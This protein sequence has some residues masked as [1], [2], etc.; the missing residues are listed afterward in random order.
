MKKKPYAVEGK[1][2]VASPSSMRLALE[3]RLLF[4]GAVVATAAQ[5][6]DDK[7]AQDQPQ[8]QDQDTSSDPNVDSAPDF[9]THA[10]NHS[11]LGGLSNDMVNRDLQHL[12]TTLPASAGDRDATT[13]L[14]IDS[15]ANG[16]Q[17]ILKNPPLHTDVRVIDASRDGYE[18]IKEILHDRGDTSQLHIQSA[19]LD[20]KQCLGSSR[21]LGN[22]NTSDTE[23]L[24]DWGD[25]IS[26]NTSINFHGGQAF[27]GKSWL[28]QVQTLTG[29][30]VRWSDKDVVDSKQA[31]STGGSQ[32]SKTT[33]DAEKE[34][35]ALGASTAEIKEVKSLVFIDTSVKDYHALLKDIDPN[36]TVILLD[37]TK[38]GVQ[39]MVNVV[40]KYDSIDAI[41][42]ISHGGT[43]QLKLG[44][45]VLNQASIQDMYADELTSMSGHLSANADILIYGCNFGQGDIGIQVSNQLAALT[46]ADIADSTNDTGAAVLG[47]DWILENQIGMIEAL[48]INAPEWDGLLTT[49]T[50]LDWQL[51]GNHTLGATGTTYTFGG[52]TNAVTIKTTGTGSIVNDYT[53]N[54]TGGTNDPTLAFSASTTSTTSG[55]T[56]EINF[57]SSA[58]P[59]GVL[60]TQFDLRNIDAK[61]GSGAWDDRVILQAF[62]INGVQL[63]GTNI[64][65]TPRQTTGQTYSISTLTN[66]VQLDGNTSSSTNFNLPSDSVNISITSTSGTAI[67][68]V[69]ILYVSGTSGTS[70]G[71]VGLSD[72]G[73]TYDKAPLANADTG[74][75]AEDATLPK[76]AANGVIQGTTGGSVADSDPDDAT[77]TLVVSGVKAGT[78]TVTQGVGVGSS[79][80][81]TYG[82]LTLTSDGSYSYIADNANSLAA[83]ATATDTFTYT[84]K[85]PTGVVSN[86]TTLTITLTGTNDPPTLTG[87]LS[88][89]VLEGGTYVLTAADLGFTDPDNVAAAETFTVSALA[90]GTVLVNGVA[91]TS[92]T[93]TQLAAGQVSFQHNGSETTS[94]SFLV[95]VEDGNQ[96]GSVPA[97]STFNF[98]V[99]PVNDPPALTGD[100]SATVLEGGT[101]VL[102]AADLGFTDP[103]NVAAAETFTVSALAN[104][105]VLVNG[106]A[107]TS[108]TGT[109]LAAGQVSF[110]HN[111]S[112]TT[113]ASFLVNVEDGNQDGSVPANS[114]FNFSVTPVNDPPALTGDLSATVL[115]GGTYVLTAAD[116]GFTDPDNVAAAETFTVSALAN[117]TVLVNGVAATSFTGTQ[118]A[119]GQVSFQHNGSETTSASFLV[120]VEDGNQDG[121]VPVNSTFNFS[122][123]PVN[124]PP[125]LTGDLSA[126]VL[127]GGTYVLTAADL[128]F[129]DPDNVAAA[130]TFTVS[131]LANGT[132]LVNGV[133]A[134][135]FTGTQL[136]AGQ[137][138][139]QHNGSETTSAS[140]LVNVEDG[141]QDGSVPANSTFNFSVTPVNDPPALTGDL[142]ATVLE[143]GT[144]VLT[145]ADLGFTDPD[146]VA[147]AETFTVS[148][149]ANGT[150]L[151]NGVAATSFTGTQLAAGQVSFQHNGSETTS[152]SFLV[153]VEDGNQDG[154][155][156]ANST[157]NFSVTPVNDPPALTGDLS[158]TVLEGG[159]YVLTAADLG[160]TDPDNV[161]AAE[162]FTVSALANGTVLVNG[163]AATSFT[164]TQLAAGQVSFQH[165]GSETTSASF[166]VNVEDG[167]QDG[168]VPAN[169]TF[170]FSVTP[171]NDP[172]ALTGDLSATVLEGGTYVLTAADLGFTDPDNVAAAETFTVSALANGTVLV[173]G[174]AATSFTGTQ[175]AAGQVSFQHNGSETTSASFLVNVE[176]GN[177]D[178]SVPANS[179]FNFSVTPVNDPPALTGDLSATV[180]EG[181]TYVLTAADLGFTDPDNVAAAETFTVS[182]LA[183]G[184]V[185]VN[186]VAATSFTGTQLAAGQVS[187]QH[188][189]SETTSA[190]F[191]VNVEDGNQDGS[192]PVNSTFNFSVTPVNDPPVAVD[193][194]TILMPLP[195]VEDTLTSL[196]L[197]G[198]DTDPDIGDTLSVQSINGISL[199]PGTAQ[200][201][202]VPNG[203]VKVSNTGVINFT[204]TSNYNG[205]VTFDYIVK[206]SSGLTDTG[207][208]HLNVTS[209]NDVVTYGNLNDNSANVPNTDAQVYEKDLPSGS[210]P[211][212][213]GEQVNGSFTLGPIASLT[214]FTLGGATTTAITAAQL[215]ASGTSPI[216]R[217]GAFGT[218]V[219]NGYNP[220]TSVVNYS[221]TLTTRANHTVAIKNE[222]YGISTIDV[223]G[224]INNS[225]SLRINI[226]DDLPIA[227]ADVD[228]VINFAGS[229][230]STSSGNVVTGIGGTDPNNADGNADKVG[231]DTNVS[232][233]TGVV[234][235]TGTVTTGVGVGGAVVSVNGYGSLTLNN[236][237]SYTYL[238]NY[239]NS[240]VAALGP[241]QTVNDTY[242]YQITDGDGDT[243]NTT[244]TITIV[245]VPA[246]VGLNDGN[247]VG[248]DGSVLESDLA[249]GTNAA[250][251]GEVLNGSFQLVSPT[252]G[253]TSLTIAGITITQAELLALATTNKVITTTN[254]MLTLNSYSYD[255]PNGTG[256]VG[257]QYTLIAPPTSA[258]AVT[259][260]F[261]V[262]LQDGVAVSTPLKTLAI[263]IIDD[264]PIASPDNASVTEDGANPIVG[265]VFGNDKIGADG[266]SASPIGP[267]TSITNSMSVSGTVN[268]TTPLIGLYGSLT[269]GTDGAYTYT[270]DNVNAAVNSLKPGQTL[271]ETYN[272]QI[273][274]NDGDVSI[275][276]LTITI[277]GVNDI[278][279][280]TPGS[281]ATPTEDGPPVAVP[282]AGTDVDGTTAAVTITASRARRKARSPTTMTATP[283]PRQSP[284]P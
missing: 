182:A 181:G 33:T 16:I 173:N 163:V 77:N 21:L 169:S 10:D 201:I 144:Y 210:T 267:V 115:E 164:G 174:V 253:V 97:N 150:V 256:T 11:A 147:A 45:A 31:I 191:L 162:T 60:N 214:S 165:N 92:F 27:D 234:A 138:S 46:G 248:T 180:L 145:A 2:R 260:N 179:T 218:L 130:E 141:N 283:P 132:V 54:Y 281:T 22:L 89:T 93:G 68:K 254:G 40:S 231:A 75:V 18:Q 205:L 208:V 5:A 192:V 262:S 101:Y 62:D 110:Q 240:V 6:M 245:G 282:L 51:V 159:T 207:T 8:V 142:S 224:D 19:E 195:I 206:D 258:V 249:A 9:T 276:S 105:T 24:I 178:G 203:T 12:A 137:V 73:I 111:G 43:G 67:G 32:D 90:N 108:F 216:T 37:P 155:V 284:Y 151:V 118:L 235:G 85:D 217:I 148:A 140:F 133:A 263:A 1:K 100:L 47:G 128:G 44:S 26:A 102:T 61:T 152:A 238:P 252:N 66:S 154:S 41:H 230:G 58:F 123:T 55:Q 215:L 171:V 23:T 72:I 113:S 156:P 42:I 83:G 269:I 13:L 53:A 209:V 149:L 185:L 225:N 59:L 190:S 264:A 220:A 63:S 200:T 143:G 261:S 176:D 79:I 212:G 272:Y 98:S 56:T 36:S 76:T 125:A 119:A 96:D 25:D 183:N 160:F 271:T 65:A 20:G 116:L 166:L 189:G 38:D 279:V 187:F 112:E 114:T 103:D 94:A 197:M 257:Y 157:F 158:A 146:N 246:V 275:S 241:G 226:V 175:L 227:V 7:A 106:V 274:D 49:T 82:H 277:N 28:N 222:V 161:A 228:E 139:F 232:P 69:T 109:Q 202:S 131:A 198:N 30:Q 255:T 70:T 237:G 204:P 3:N 121:S 170:N 80:L 219:I 107:A 134:T 153:N 84:V 86:T 15:R 120:N 167:N 213:T 265:N 247:V 278:P 221:Y 87:D 71:V 233:V 126:T 270:I 184:T 124:D 136:A 129:T 250:G 273:T 251:N 35:T 199:I 39:Q 223:E 78:G 127:E 229:P 239:S 57:N 74:A 4:D 244:L 99:T 64:T 188:N 280:A 168:S 52:L 95:N 194:G 88:A 196:D 122:V 48:T 268:G 236:N 34:K 211:S 81:G 14:V 186:G 17:E 243:A 177:Q 104:G 172:P 50:T 135:S 29:G 242:T 91:A 117:G 193:D 266:V 259:D